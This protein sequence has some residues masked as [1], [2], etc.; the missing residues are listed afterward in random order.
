MLL[1]EDPQTGSKQLMV[2]HHYYHAERDCYSVRVSALTTT[3]NDFMSGDQAAHWRTVYE[4]QPCLA[5]HPNGKLRFTGHQTGGTLVQIEPGTFLIALG[6]AGFD[7]VQSAD[8]YPQDMTNDFGKIIEVDLISGQSRPITAGHRSPAGLYAETSGRLWLTEHGPRG[9]DELNLVRPGRDYGWPQHSL[10]VQYGEMAWPAQVDAEIAAAF[11]SPEFAWTPSI[12]ISTLLGLRGREFEKW[13][14]DLLVSSLVDRALYR[15]QLADGRPILAERIP[16][17]ERV[18]D[19]VQDE[20]GRIIFW[21]DRGVIGLI[22][23]AK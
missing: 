5:L 20:R 14:G 1:I 22:E 9:G 17:Y 16:V 18:R 8:A 11:E 21:T 13:R 4:A 7:G 6:D 23:D 12:G 3:W 10:G 19:V 15:V 2:S